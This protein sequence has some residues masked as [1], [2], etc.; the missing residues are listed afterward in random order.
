MP[1]RRVKV[2]VIGLGANGRQHAVAHAAS[3]KAEL[4]A[5]GDVNESKLH[6]VG[7]ELGVRKLCRN[8]DD[9]FADPE[10]EAVSIH[11]PD[12][13]HK[14]PFLKA[15]KAGKHVFVEKPLANTEADVAEMV[16]A[17]AGGG[18]SRKIGVGYILRFNPVFEAIHDTVQARRL[19]RVYYMEADYVHNLHRKKHETDPLTGYNWYLREQVPMVSGGSHCIDLLSWIKADSPVSV[20]GY[21]NHFAFPELS[22]DDCMVALFRFRDGAVAKVAA[23]WG[24]ECPKPPFYNLRIY[25]TEGTVER[26]EI[27]RRAAE[28][29]GRWAFEPVEASRIQGHPYEP[30]IDDWLTA[31]LED[32]PVRTSLKDGANSTMAALRAVRACREGKELPIPVF[33]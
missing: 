16:E 25:G 3:P 2:A 28:P 9:L 32:R 4:V 10:I 33:Q 22:T 14:E 11:T 26:D 8:A 27:C 7:N 12:G 18:R 20:V 19:G 13:Q 5:L 6:H 15:L 29:G 23:L 1:N 31:I 24:P 21:S 30:E 17:A